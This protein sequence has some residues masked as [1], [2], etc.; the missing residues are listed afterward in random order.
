MTMM[1]VNLSQNIFLGNN[2]IDL[3]LLTSKS[4][5]NS[6]GMLSYCDIVL[7]LNF[8]SFTGKAGGSHWL[9]FVELIAVVVELVEDW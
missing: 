8:R 6:W 4:D 3:H 5:T 7:F 9:L 2:T 1:E